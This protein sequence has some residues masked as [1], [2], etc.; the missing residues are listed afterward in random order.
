MTVF[1][2]TFWR[3]AERQTDRG[4]KEVSFKPFSDRLSG[5]FSVEAKN[6]AEL[7]ARVKEHIE[8]GVPDRLQPGEQKAYYARLAVEEYGADAW[9]RPGLS[10]TNR[11]GNRKFAHCDEAV[12]RV[13]KALSF[14][15]SA[16]LAEVKASEGKVA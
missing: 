14:D 5:Y 15:A 8:V 16:Y 9:V 4:Y 10:V 6:E 11:Q 2:L 1:N 13:Y 12:K 3:Q 7:L